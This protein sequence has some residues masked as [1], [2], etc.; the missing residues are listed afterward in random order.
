M[1]AIPK[2]PQVEDGH[3][4]IANE[5]FEAIMAFS[6]T[7]HQLKVLLAVLRKTYGY[8]KKEDDVSASQLGALCRLH[9]PH[10]TAALNSLAEMGVIYKRAGN[11]GTLIG[12]NKDYSSWVELVASSRTVKAPAPRTLSAVGSKRH[13]YVYRITNPTS[14]D[15]YIGVRSC[16]CLPTQDRYIGSG[17]WI[18]TQDKRVLVKEVLAEFE[19]REDAEASEILHIRS[20]GAGCQNGRLYAGTG[21]VHRTDSVHVQK[22]DQ[23]CTDPVLLGST[24]SVHTKDNLPKDN[25]QNESA[26]ADSCGEQSVKLALV[27]TPPPVISLPVK[28]GSE[29]EITEDLVAEWSAAYPGVDVRGELAK[30]RVW[31]RASPQNLKTRR[32]MGKFVVGWLARSAKP[33]PGFSSARKSAHGN[34]SLQDYHAGVAADGTF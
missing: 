4:K 11:Y 20:A 13:H 30:A 8:G 18:A 14:S 16:D 1:N 17:N 9:R 21:S 19:T 12:I 32:G 6:F 27:P 23:G 7:S 2:S 25:Q 31:L 10:V 22:V 26:N 28:D 5:L 29:F 3:I 15:F 33:A 24:E 34:F